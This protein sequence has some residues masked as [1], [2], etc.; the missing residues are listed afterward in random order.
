MDH[1]KFRLMLD[2]ILPTFVVRKL[3]K[4]DDG[5]TAYKMNHYF[6]KEYKKYLTKPI[7]EHVD[8]KDLN[9]IATLHF[10]DLKC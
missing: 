3:F 6:T 4:S 10:A 8:T 1:F 9:C 2:K 7:I 5:Y